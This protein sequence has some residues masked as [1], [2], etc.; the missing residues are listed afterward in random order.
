LHLRTDPANTPS[1]VLDCNRRRSLE[2]PEL[3]VH[4]FIVKLWLDDA[5]HKDKTGWHGYIT[6]VPSGERRYVL[7][8]RDIQN[9]VK[10]YVEEIGTETSFIS[11][12]GRRLH[13]WLR[14]K[15]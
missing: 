3:K 9:F 2:M 5:C 4:S 14:R 1:V 7:E 13:L 15:R 6:H 11:R 12:L 8:M 10:T